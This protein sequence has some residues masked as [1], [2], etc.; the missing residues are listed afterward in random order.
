MSRILDPPAKARDD[1]MAGRVMAAGKVGHTAA[2]VDRAKEGPPLGRGRGEAG[3]GGKGVG[4]GN[5][6]FAVQLGGFAYLPRVRQ[7]LGCLNK[8]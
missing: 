7:G 4:G 2:D 6:G 3:V 8:A 1:E 5:K